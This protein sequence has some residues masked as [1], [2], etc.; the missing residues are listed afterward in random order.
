MKTTNQGN[1]LNLLTFVDIKMF[2]H[3]NCKTR[4]AVWFCCSASDPSHSDWPAIWDATVLVALAQPRHPALLC[5]LA[6]FD[7]WLSLWTRNVAC[8]PAE[9]TRYPNVSFSLK[10]TIGF[11]CS[12]VR[13]HSLSSPFLELLRFEEI[14]PVR[15]WS[16]ILAEKETSK[17]LNLMIKMCLTMCVLRVLRLEEQPYHYTYYLSHR[18]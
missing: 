2:Y 1:L 12:F 18:R 17:A 3:W 15:T 5:A 16:S 13:S 8:L 7:N 9:L 6:S 14:K 11:W 10:K 4:P